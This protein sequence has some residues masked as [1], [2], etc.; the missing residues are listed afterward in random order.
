MCEWDTTK[1]AET[2]RK[3]V[4]KR[5]TLHFLLGLNRDLD[6]VKGRVMVTKPFPEIKAAVAEVR[7]EEPRCNVMLYAP[8]PAAEGSAL[9]TAVDHA[10]LYSKSSSSKLPINRSFVNFVGSFGIPRVSV[11]S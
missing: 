5:R 2:Y 4:D 9:Q 7:G 6:D 3:A 11:S 10:A 1:D 8:K